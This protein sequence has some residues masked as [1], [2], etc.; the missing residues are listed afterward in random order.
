M[1]ADVANITHNFQC[2]NKI[3]VCFSL[4]QLLSVGVPGRQAAFHKVT[5]GSRFLLSFGSAIF[6]VWPPRLSCLSAS[7][8][9]RRKEHGGSCLGRFSFPFTFNCPEPYPVATPNCKGGWEMQSSC[10]LMKRKW[11]WGQIARLYLYDTHEFQRISTS[12]APSSFLPALGQWRTER[13]KQKNGWAMPSCLLLTFVLP[14]VKLK[15]TPGLE[16]KCIPGLKN[17][18]CPMACHQQLCSW[19]TLI[20]CPASKYKT[21]WVELWTIIPTSISWA[22]SVSQALMLSGLFPVVPKIAQPKPKVEA[23]SSWSH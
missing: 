13:L 5:K 23:K 15:L 1:P 17:W 7:S 22:L 14:S 8:L 16:D 11:A 12:A 9:Q 6:K 4:T 3:A 2:L 20:F 19:S 10:V 18:R 21:L